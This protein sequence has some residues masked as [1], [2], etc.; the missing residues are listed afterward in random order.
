MKRH[1]FKSKFSLRYVMFRPVYYRDALCLG[2]PQ[3]CSRT[4]KYSRILGVMNRVVDAF[5]SV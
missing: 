1:V 2:K 4:V 3:C 5:N